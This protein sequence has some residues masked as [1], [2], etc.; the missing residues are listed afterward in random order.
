MHYFY[1]KTIEML[2]FFFYLFHGGEILIEH[3]NCHKNRRIPQ[4]RFGFL[5]LVMQKKQKNKSQNEPTRLR[6]RKK[7]YLEKC[8]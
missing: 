7:K 6:I 2:N 5:K 8:E 4:T 1:A 3:M